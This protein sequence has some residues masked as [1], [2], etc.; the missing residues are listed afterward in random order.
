[1]DL[2]RLTDVLLTCC[3]A[4]AA[5]TE[6]PG[7]ITRTFLRPPFH[8]A[9]ALLTDW[10]RAAGLTVRVDAAGNLIGHR[11][12]RRENAR[13]FLVGSH[14][15]TVPDAGRY[16][17]PLGVLLGIAAAQALDGRDFPVA[18]DVIAFS[19]EE[20]VRFRTPYL[21][22]RAV[23]GR[24]D[25]DLLHLI[26]ADGVT[27]A[28]ALRDFGLDSDAIPAAAYPPG[29]VAG[30]LEAHI[31]QG[32]VLESLNQSLAVVE[33]I[34]GQSRRWL[35]FTGKAGH[36]GTQPMEYRRDALAA[37]A[38]FIMHV[39]RTARTTAGLRATVGSL[40]V[41]P[42]AVNVVPGTARLSL[43]V[44]HADDA[45]RERVTAGLLDQARAIAVG[46]D[47]TFT[48][49][50][51]TDQPAVPMDPALTER[52]AAAVESAGPAPYRMP[53]GAGHDAVVM[54]GL[55]PTAMLFLRSPGGI[56][57]HPDEAVRRE[58]VRA[59]LDAMA[60]FLAAELDR[61]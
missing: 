2:D 37:A 27:L 39:E 9:H 44:R 58:D 36:A 34:V 28:Q 16:D 42:G 31:E 57:H 18:L 10:M 8:Q 52:L 59:A 4:L 5:C 30:Y 22:S 19:E 45:V 7:R 40:E 26:D 1:M 41:G 61:E 46:R 54:A 17:G 53:S 20:G 55:S 12:T 13:V 48:V 35:C 51:A 24:F 21:G 23:A 43:D 33:A 11:P 6:F 14:V 25:L 56:S 60:R 49:R 38:E 50:S 29:R 15:D 32:P 3:D 47:M